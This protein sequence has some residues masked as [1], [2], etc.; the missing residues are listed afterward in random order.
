MFICRNLIRY[1]FLKRKGRILEKYFRVGVIANTHGIKGEAKV[2]PT[3]DDVKRFDYLKEVVLD[4]KEGPMTLHISSVKYFKNLV[5]VKFKEIN[6]INDLLPYKGCDLLVSRENAIPL[7]EGEYYIADIIGSKVITDED[8]ELGVL[9]DVLQTGANDVFV[10][11]M[12]D[13]KEV[14]L[15]SIP[16]CVLDKDLEN[17][18]VKVHLMKGLL[19]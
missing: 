15:P 19:D 17:K 1:V 14:L 13:G 8:E 12:K 16:Q 2:Y 7:E 3:T 10:V 11:K 5:I 9:K 4:S 6:D 18:I